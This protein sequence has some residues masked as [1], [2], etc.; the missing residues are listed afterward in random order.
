MTTK[1]SITSMFIYFLTL[2]HILPGGR[3]RFLDRLCG[4]LWVAAISGLALPPIYV[5]QE[6]FRPYLSTITGVVACASHV[7]VPA[8]QGKIIKINKC[9]RCSGS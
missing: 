6:G 8:L 7:L 2:L 1:M 3:N 9:H 4:L 5:L